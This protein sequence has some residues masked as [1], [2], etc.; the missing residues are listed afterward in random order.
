VRA[1]PLALA[2]IAVLTV[3]YAQVYAG[4]SL[5]D[6]VAQGD[7]DR[8]LY[9]IPITYT[10]ALADYLAAGVPADLRVIAPSEDLAE[11]L[12]ALLRRRPAITRFD[13]RRA[14]PLPG[15]GGGIY[16]VVE[17]RSPAA[18]LLARLGGNWR[19]RQVDE[20]G[21]PVYTV[22][23]LPGGLADS[24]L[25]GELTPTDLRFEHGPRLLGTGVPRRVAAGETI[26]V[27]ALWRAD[28]RPPPGPDVFVAYAHLLDASGRE[29]ASAHDWGH[30]P[31]TNDSADQW[32]SWLSIP[33]PA[34]LL[35]GA[36]WVEYGVF[37]EP[38]VRPVPYVDATGR[39][40]QQVR[41]GPLKCVGTARPAVPNPVQTREARFG[42]T[43]ALRGYDLATT[44]GELRVSLHWQALAT[45]PADYQVF[46]HLVD[47]SGRLVAQH[48]APPAG[49]PTSLWD[50]GD[51]VVDAHVLK[52]PEGL[53][54]GRYR[55]V[56]GLYHLPDGQ[57]LPAADASGRAPD[58]ALPLA[59][60]ALP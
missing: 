22:Y 23:R 40:G 25:Q 47:G 55:L 17:D 31:S 1:I 3:S 34:D 20:L 51:E 8:Y 24:L 4:R 54:P 42:D 44:A 12:T 41:L 38:G 10:S 52:L 2:G 7:R 60:V 58:D 35:S 9:G 45:P 6:H 46:V 30:L 39:P 16:V 57:R 36:C 43:I 53:A 13:G 56:V 5:T 49:L 15:P 28:R 14:L 50:A 37:R 32:L 19:L 59:D 29:L 11:A 33:A 48:D 27:A 21:R 18:K 26:D